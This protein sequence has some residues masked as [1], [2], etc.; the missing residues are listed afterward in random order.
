VVG[1]VLIDAA[2]RHAGRRILRQV[3]DHKL[4]AHAITHRIPI[5][6]GAATRCAPKLGIPFWV[7][8]HD[9]DAGRGASADRRV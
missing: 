3:K 4:A 9:A 5:T 7:G 1:D 8:E 2:S 6:K